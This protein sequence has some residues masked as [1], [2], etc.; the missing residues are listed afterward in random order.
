MR[1]TFLLRW[2]VTPRTKPTLDF[3]FGPVGHRATLAGLEYAFTRFRE[4]GV[5]VPTT[6]RLVLAKEL[7]GRMIGKVIDVRQSVRLR[8]D[9]AEAQRV[10]TDFYHLARALNPRGGPPPKK[11]RN[12]L[13][14]A[15]CGHLNAAA[16]DPVSVAARNMQFQLWLGSWFTAGGRP[17]RYEEPDLAVTYW[18]RWHG[19]AAKRIQSPAK[20]VERVQQA[21]RQVRT[22][23][24]EGFVAV[25]F[26]NYSPAFS[27]RFAG[28]R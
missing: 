24:G 3:L 14:R 17:V 11:F 22:R 28:L 26:D 19:V 10:A 20:I 27:K 7:L 15:Y 8:R 23:R 6:S 9:L 21:A 4:I 13:Q 18:Y 1:E 25:T 5:S 2:V 16:Q 12:D